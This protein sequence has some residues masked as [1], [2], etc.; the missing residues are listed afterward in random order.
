MFTKTDMIHDLSAIWSAVNW[1]FPYFERLEFDWDKTY[2]EYLDKIDSI[3]SEYEF[4][5]LL[6]DF[7]NLLN[8]GHTKYTFPDS[9]DSDNTSSSFSE[10][11]PYSFENHILT[12]QINHFMNDC[13]E[14]VAKLLT[15]FDNIKLVR[16]DVSENIGGNS[17]FANAVAKL[18]ISGQYNVFERWQQIHVAHQD[19]RYSQICMYS[20][21]FLEYSLASGLVTADT[22]SEAKDKWNK[23]R[24]YRYSTVKFGDEGNEALYS[25][26]VE[27]VI[28]HKTVSA[29]EDFAAIFKV[30]NRGKLIGKST[31]GSTGSP[32]FV[33]NLRCKGKAQIVSVGYRLVT[34]EEFVGCGIQPD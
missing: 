20:P 33:P 21:E 15:S 31:Y 4:H 2:L 18:F 27:I 34:G 1:I 22:I 6:K 17:I 5:C 14:F 19:A 7:L 26:P 24:L 23:H 8:D 32:Y 30:T 13:S 28:S 10:Q 25:G 3:E 29:G 12:I 11:V 9:C 16:I